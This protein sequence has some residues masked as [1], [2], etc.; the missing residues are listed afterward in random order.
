MTCR[1]V[2]TTL[3]VL[4]LLALALRVGA[5]VFFKPWT[6]AKANAIEHRQIATNLVKGNGF[7][8]RGLGSQ[9]P[10]P[11]SVQSPPYPML[12]AT[13]DKIFGVD[14]PGAYIT[15]MLINALAGAA[16]VWLTYVLAKT[17]GGNDLVGLIAA[18]A[19]AIWPSQLTNCTPIGASRPY[20]CRR[21]AMSSACAPGGTIIAIGSPGTTR[22]STNTTTTTPN[23]VG[24]AQSRRFAR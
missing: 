2:T 18:G 3:I 21:R 19:C 1:Q 10:R 6:P 7:A 11:S 12:L 14:S 20:I 13:L 15:A 22:S 4:C 24:S 23:K 17:L 16:T 9:I 8:Y 5:I